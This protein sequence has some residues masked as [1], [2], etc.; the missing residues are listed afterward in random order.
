MAHITITAMLDNGEDLA[1]EVEC[2]FDVDFDIYP[3]EPFSWGHG[4]GS[5]IAVT[6]TTLIGAKVGGKDRSRE[7]IIDL[8]GDAAVTWAEE[9]AH[10]EDDTLTEAA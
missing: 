5:E 6:G 8:F 4:R 10:F 1:A 3:A 9:H 2:T 7:Y